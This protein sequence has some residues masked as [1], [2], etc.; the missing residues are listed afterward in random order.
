VDGPTSGVERQ[1]MP[2]RHLSLTKIRV[3][4]PRG[5]RTKAVKKVLETAAVNE[6]W[7]KTGTAKRLNAQRIRANLT[8]F[9]RFKVMVLKQMVLFLEVSN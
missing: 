9:D 6:Q 7:A 1:V 5:A 3:A 8:D 2:F 4:M